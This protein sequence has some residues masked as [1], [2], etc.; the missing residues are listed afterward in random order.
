MGEIGED[1]MRLHFDSRVRLKFHGA[2][3]TSDAG[4]L[5]CRELDDAL[6]LTEAALVHLQES[7]GGRNVQHGL[8]P[9]LRQSVYSRLAGY[10]D[11]NDAQRLAQDSAIRVVSSR[12]ASERQAASSNTVSRFETE[13]LTRG[14]NLEGLAQLNAEWVERAMSQTTHRRVVLDMDSSESPVHGHEVGAA[15]N[16]HFKSVCYHP[17]FCFNQFGDCEGALLRPG[18]VHSADRWRE[19]LEPIVE[20]Y[21]SRSGVRLLYRADAAFAKPEVYEYLEQRGIGYAIRLSANE[22]LQREIEPLLQPPIEELLEQPI[23]RYHDFLYQAG[24]WDRPRRVVA[25][26]EWHQGE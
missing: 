6:G 23:V 13:V 11:T 24:S 16:G 18:S 2:T 20:R 15:Y 1:G 19:M 22:V 12:R 3:I 17:L 26:A 5:A 9:L 7:R 4:L 21:S 10:E 14:N 25:K 8:V